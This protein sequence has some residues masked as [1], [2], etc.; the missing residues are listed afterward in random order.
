MWTLYVDG[1]SNKKGSRTKIILEGPRH[2]Q[3]E[4]S[5]RFKFKTFN[6]Q[7]EYE[8]PIACLILARDMGAM[9]FICRVSGKRS[10]AVT[11]LS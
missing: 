7:A 6:N 1:S 4:V 10:F 9:K 11:I 3:L 8:A 5:L 2:F